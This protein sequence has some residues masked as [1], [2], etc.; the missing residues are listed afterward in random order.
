MNEIKQFFKGFKKGFS[1]FGHNISIII[2]SILLLIVYLIGVGM[3]SI[4]A[5]VFNKHFL[6]KKIIA[7]KTT[8]WSDLNLKKKPIDEYYRQF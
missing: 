8:Y 6:Q 5:K 3:T 4:F 7:K 2:N 1:A